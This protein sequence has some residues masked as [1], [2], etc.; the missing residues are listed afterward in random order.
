MNIRIIGMALALVASMAFAPLVSAEGK[1]AVVDLGR[2]IFSTE[3]AKMRLEQAKKK[4]DIAALEAEYDSIAAN[5]KKLQKEI[6]SKQKSMSQ[7]Q[8]AEYRKKMDYYKV[9]MDVVVRKI[10]AESQAL[11]QS[12]LN[13]LRPKAGEALKELVKEE[14]ISVLLTAESAVLVDPKLDITA[15][16]IDRLNSKTR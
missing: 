13:E 11:Q 1:T 12:I 8:A 7:E 15:K 9:D 6:E 4:S 10:Q 2:A 5:A 14:G 3:T 16:L